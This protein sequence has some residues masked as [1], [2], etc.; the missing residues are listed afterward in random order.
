M[1]FPLIEKR[2]F[3]T[4]LH[5][6]TFLLAIGGENIEPHSYGANSDFDILESQCSIMVYP[7]DGTIFSLDENPMISVAVSGCPFPPAATEVKIE[8][9]P[10]APHFSWQLE[11][12]LSESGIDL[13]LP[14]T[15][16]D[17]DYQGTVRIGAPYS[18]LAPVH[19]IR[20]TLALPVL[21][22]VFPIPGFAFGRRA[23]PWLQVLVSDAGHAARGIR[24]VNHLLD[25]RVDGTSIGRMRDTNGRRIHLPPGVG[26]RRVDVAV[27]DAAGRAT[28]ANASLT[29]VVADSV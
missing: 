9:G 14:H 4:T 23:A 3:F 29:V 12:G 27:L 15:L 26:E 21:E 7:S 25:V 2:N 11:Y 5:C 17:G 6:V 22:I 1:K 8:F 24:Q 10:N 13:D 16:P 28:A 20:A 18:L 19:F